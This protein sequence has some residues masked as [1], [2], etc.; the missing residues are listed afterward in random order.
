M[1]ITRLL[2]VATLI[3]V[4]AC[5]GEGITRPPP[6]Q[7]RIFNA[8]AN[9]ESI[10]F[11]REQQPNENSA[12]LAYGDA[13]TPRWDSGQYD[14]H[15]DYSTPSTGPVRAFSFSE[16]LSPDLD[17]IFVTIAPG[18]DP[19]ALS[20]AIEHLPD[21]ATTPRVSFIHAFEGLGN[22]DVYVQPPGTILSAV[23]PQG[24]IAF[25]AD[26]LSLELA[27][28]TYRIYLTT[29]G[30][31]NDVAFESTD[32]PIGEG[33]DAVLVVSDPA[34][35]GT[36][37]IAVNGIGSTSATRI[38][39]AGLASAVRIVQ[40]LDDRQD[41]DIYV[42]DTLSPPLL[43]AQAFGVLS[44]YLDI[45]AGQRRL[46]VTPVGN[47][48]TEELLVDY[49]AFAGALFTVLIAVNADGE[50]QSQ[51]VFEDK[52][53][54]AGQATLRILNGAG[55]FGPLSVYLEEPGT[56]ITTAN[57]GIGLVSPGVSPRIPLAPGDYELTLEE[58]NTGTIV[59]GPELL[60]M[61]DGGVYGLLF[62]NGA[63]GSTVDIVR[64]DDFVP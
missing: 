40:S 16:T 14:F 9:V 52:R 41:R 21:G 15:L 26:V 34:G 55:L 23:A 1:K 24:T 10:T 31:P 44:D 36:S 11:R 12:V 63:G 2:F 17:H 18:G 19:E 4:T 59:A 28:Q 27:P 56:D 22:L 58:F 53:S 51:D 46:I 33:T 60:T 38:S 25:A 61:D 30:D 48:G 39:Q 49:T 57:P 6:T 45:S 8:A 62:V 5:E 29:A 47:P 64:F 54:I 37:D 35:Q 50:F 7:V 32:Q 3:A 13:A 43:A 20:F 42:G